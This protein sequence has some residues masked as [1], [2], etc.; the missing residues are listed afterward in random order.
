VEEAKAFLTE[1]HEE[2]HEEMMEGHEERL[3]ELFEKSAEEM[4][5]RGSEKGPKM[6]M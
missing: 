1:K 4:P 6:E 3:D 5:T 2:K